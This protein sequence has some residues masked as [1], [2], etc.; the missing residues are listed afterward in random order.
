MT[1]YST[2]CGMFTRSP[3]LAVGPDSPLKLIRGLLRTNM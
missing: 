2:V 3:A 1:V